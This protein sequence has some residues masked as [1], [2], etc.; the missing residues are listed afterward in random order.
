MLH[1]QET[2]RGRESLDGETA[3]Q[4]AEHLGGGF[5]PELIDVELDNWTKKSA[6][7]LAKKAGMQE[8]Y[9]LVFDPAS[10]EVHG[11]WLSLKESNLSWCV[12]PLHRLH[13]LPT[14]MEPPLHLNTVI[15][16]QRTYEH[17]RGLAVSLLGYPAPTESLEEIQ[18]GTNPDI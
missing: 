12:Q 7:D 6:R 8:F 18:V 15:A 13:R 3:D 17:C 9:Q 10:S 1:L 11:T 4:I 2:Y 5:T 14:Y 16:T